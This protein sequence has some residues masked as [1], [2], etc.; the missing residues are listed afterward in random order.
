MQ[1]RGDFYL[2]CE[3]YYKPLPYFCTFK[4]ECYE[5]PL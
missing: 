1:V 4:I 2:E 3:H 5:M